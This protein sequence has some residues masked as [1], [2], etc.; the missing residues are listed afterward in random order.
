MFDIRVKKV[1]EFTDQSTL[2]WSAKHFNSMQTPANL[3][4]D[5]PCSHNRNAQIC[6][7]D[8]INLNS[9]KIVAFSI[10]DKFI[11][12]EFVNYKRPSSHPE[13]RCFEWILIYLMKLGKIGT[14]FK[15]NNFKIDKL[16]KKHN[17]TVNIISNINQ[18]V[19]NFRI[20]TPEV[21]S[22]FSSETTNYNENFHSFKARFLNKV[23]NYG[24]S[25]V[26]RICASI[27]KYNKGYCYWILDPLKKLHANKISIHGLA[28]LTDFLG[29]TKKKME[30]KKE[31]Y[32]ADNSVLEKKRKKKKKIG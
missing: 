19:K 27:L 28:G 11:N 25:S 16:I 29:K 10:L 22:F 15:D 9:G 12:D 31:R 13:T 24:K 17:W 4:F 23:Y 3:L 7:T 21:Q 30:W 18:K 8:F 2:E 32:H 6:V 1:T 20:L 26:A 14:I 5:A